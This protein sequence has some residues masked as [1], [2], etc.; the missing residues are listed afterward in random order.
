MKGNIMSFLGEPV[1]MFTV[2]IIVAIIVV[3]LFFGVKADVFIDFF[4]A[5][6]PK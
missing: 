2:G 1:L 5:F 6:A 4:K 3:I